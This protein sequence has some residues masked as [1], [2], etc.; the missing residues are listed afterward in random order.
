M[1]KKL[2]SITNENNHKILTILGVKLKLHNSRLANN[3]IYDGI[4]QV[5]QDLQK[6]EVKKTFHR[7]NA[8]EEWFPKDYWDSFINQDLTEKYIKLTKGLDKDSINVINRTLSRIQKFAKYKQIDFELSKE[9]Y[10]DIEKIR[11]MWMNGVELSGKDEIYA[12][13]DYIIASN[14][15]CATSLYYDCYI[16][17]I[18]D[19][20]KIMNNHIIDAGAFVGDSPLVLSKYTNKQVHA[21]EPL[22]S[23]YNKMLKTLEINN[24]T[25]VIPVN[26]GLGD[27]VEDSQINIISN[28]EVAAS[29][30]KDYGNSVL[31]SAK[32]VTID[33]YVKENN[34]T[35]GFIKTDV[36]GF[37]QQL[38]RGAEE[39][40]RRD[41]PVL[42]ISIYHTFDDFF[43]IKPWIEDLNLGYKFKVVK[44]ASEDICC[45]V[46]LLA[47]V[48]KD[49]N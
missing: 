42:S 13:N 45:D 31:E 44:S 7:L 27:K 4:I 20:E 10:E 40:I 11:S 6:L 1:F 19:K 47:E 41:K 26:A 30:L 25:N 2:F 46:I 12:F 3:L 9:E 29:F 15:C 28:G 33:K 14:I 38:L 48:P 36:E 8:L 5:K 16:N 34:I 32:I 39:T 22:L 23:N 35:V 49:N 43:N 21:F 37:E 24:I 17:K 18:S